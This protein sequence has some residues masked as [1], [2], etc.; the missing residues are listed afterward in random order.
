MITPA[1]R[2][3]VPLLAATVPL[4]AKDEQE[5]VDEIEVELQGP[6]DR[7]LTGTHLLDDLRVVSGQT[8]EDDDPHET[9]NFSAG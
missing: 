1:P 8:R 7:A 2:Q 9:I 4:H 3:E 5:E 6:E